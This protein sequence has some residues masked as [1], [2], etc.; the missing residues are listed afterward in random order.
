MKRHRQDVRRPQGKD[1][2][3]DPA[4]REYARLA[5]EY[6]ARWASYVEATTRETL[7]RL[8][9]KASDRVLD[10]G[11]G[12]GSLL[13]AIAARSP[14][15]ELVGVDLSRE[16]LA[17]AHK[18]VG[19][20]ASLITAR[21]ESLPFPDSGFDVVVSCSAFHYFRRPAQSLR[22]FRRVLRPMSRLVITDWCHDYVACRLLDFVLRILG[23][24]HF[25]TYGLDEC[26]RALRD[27]R[28]GRV[29]AEHY[30]INWF[31]GLMTARARR[32][33]DA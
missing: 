1:R 23:R 28:F 33:P 3:G 7:K 13:R 9:L 12:T 15:A 21:A 18:K 6:D 2:A 22:E 29:A 16:M 24:S 14:S 31:W 11:C 17:V 19:E 32:E 20:R 4:A 26:R 5:A 25:R 30:R 8:D 10:V 27:A